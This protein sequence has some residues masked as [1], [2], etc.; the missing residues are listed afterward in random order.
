MKNKLSSIATLLTV[1]G[2]IAFVATARADKGGSSSTVNPNRGPN[3]NNVCNQGPNTNN[4]ANPNKGPN[5][6]NVANPN[7][8]PNTN[9]V[10]NEEKIRLVPPT[11]VKAEGSADFR[12]QV[13]HVRL[14]VEAE[15]PGDAAGTVLTVTV[16]TVDIGTITIGAT[17]EGQLELEAEDGVTVPAIVPGS[18]VMVTDAAGDLI[19]AGQF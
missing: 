19:L 5:T 6:N 14:E 2:F 7:Q 3:T 11:G 17:G 13:G 15:V 16:D 8:G 12:S 1:C 18:V 4:A 10:A 9:N